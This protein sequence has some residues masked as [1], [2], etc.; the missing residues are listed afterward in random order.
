MDLRDVTLVCQDW[1]G[2]I[3]L[4]QAATMPERF[5]RLVIMNTW[6]HHPGFEY[7]P[8]IRTW[9]AAWTPGG[10]F[11]RNTPNAALVPLISAR[12]AER[13][14]IFAALL[15]DSEPKFTDDALRMYAGFAAPFRGLPD[16]A[17]NGLR[18]FPLSIPLYDYDSG[19]GA[20]Q[21]MHHHLLLGWSKPVHVVWGGADDV[22]TENWGRTWAEQLGATFDLIPD[23][24]HFLQNTHGEAVVDIVLDR[25]NVE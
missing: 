25:I 3:G 23:A 5:A 13:E 18:M 10:L 8:A 16:E 14:A 2:P 15:S 21:T 6:L 19:N 11:D 24:D 22:F 9:I 12:K 7:T 17:F 20:A 4:A 1:G